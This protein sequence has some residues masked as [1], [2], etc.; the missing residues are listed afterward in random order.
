MI[1]VPKRLQFVQQPKDVQ[2][3]N[4]RVRETAEWIEGNGYAMSEVGAKRIAQERAKQRR[5]TLI[6]IGAFVKQN[7]DD[8]G[9]ISSKEMRKH[10][11]SLLGNGADPELSEV[12][13]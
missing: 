2:E 13:K 11:N 4:Q 10:L 3:W 8:D 5:E 12:M 9:S 7:V 6:E 1:K